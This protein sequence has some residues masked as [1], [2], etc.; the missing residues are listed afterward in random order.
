MAE[1]VHE[2]MASDDIEGNP[3]NYNDMHFACLK[4]SVEEVQALIKSHP[5]LCL[6]KDNHGR[7]P[8][9]IAAMEGPED[10]VRALVSA[11]PESVKL[12]TGLGETAFHLALKNGQYYSFPVVKMLV[13][14]SVVQ[15]K[16]KNDKGL[17]A[18]E[19]FYEKISESVNG[20]DKYLGEL[21][22]D[23][24]AKEGTWANRSSKEKPSHSRSLQLESPRF[25]TTSLLENTSLAKKALLMAVFVSL[26]MTAFGY[27]PSQFRQ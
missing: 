1:E 23:A 21:L 12:T 11:Y 6:E 27:M 5:G 9:H 16:A 17:T 13:D 24:E 15:V 3:D 8:L 2:A 18:L 4:Q 14:N 7:I 20:D 26:G 25:M 19:L 10:V 22:R